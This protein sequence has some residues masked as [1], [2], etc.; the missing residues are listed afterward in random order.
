MSLPT[1]IRDVT[2]WSKPTTSRVFTIANKVLHLV[3]TLNAQFTFETRHM[4][5]SLSSMQKPSPQEAI[6]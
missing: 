2:L 1:V 5:C 3:L 4:A 6:A